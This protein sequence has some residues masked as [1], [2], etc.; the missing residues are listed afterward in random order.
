MKIQPRIESRSEQNY[1]AIRSKVTMKEIPSLLPPLINEVFDWLNKNKIEPAGPPFFHYL[2]FENDKLL[3][4]V[5]VLVV[6]AIKENNRIVAGIFPAGKYLI[7]NYIGNYSNLNL[8]HSE[9]ERWREK[10][11]IRFQGTR[12]DFYPIDPATEPNPD[13]W[14][15]IITAQIE[16]D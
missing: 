16:S 8:V 7:T 6:S 10:N 5:G 13:K 11:K 4:D 15:T 14:Q 2:K 3:V 1:A 9:I 12:T